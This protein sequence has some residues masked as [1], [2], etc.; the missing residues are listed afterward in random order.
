MGTDTDYKYYGN[1][2]WDIKSI[3]GGGVITPSNPPNRAKRT[4]SIKNTWRKGIIPTPPL[5]KTTYYSDKNLTSGYL[6]PNSFVEI[7]EAISDYYY[8]S[9]AF[10]HVRNLKKGSSEKVKQELNASNPIRLPPPT[11][12]ELGER[13]K[14]G[15]EDG[16]SEVYDGKYM[17]VISDSV[18]DEI[19][20]PTSI[21]PFPPDDAYNTHEGFGDVLKSQPE[22]LADVPNIVLL[23]VLSLLLIFYF[24]ACR[25]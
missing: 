24:T 16:Q 13:K 15:E 19:G 21:F 11:I 1:Y 17:Y 8:P 2:D 23:F 12:G 22:L 14:D 5:Y 25:K 7:D 3:K 6:N 18:Q 4:S 20:I 9:Q 10:N